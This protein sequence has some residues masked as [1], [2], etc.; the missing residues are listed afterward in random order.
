MNLQN[1][2]H[3]ARGCGYNSRAVTHLRSDVFLPRGLSSIEVSSSKSREV[4]ETLDQHQRSFN[5]LC[6]E[7]NKKFNFQNFEKKSPWKFFLPKNDGFIQ[8]SNDLVFFYKSFLNT[9]SHHYCFSTLEPRLFELR[10]SRL[11]QG[12]FGSQNVF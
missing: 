10:L 8:N 6:S 3:A 5:I 11:E 9:S 2:D 4:R 12:K 7:H 1:S